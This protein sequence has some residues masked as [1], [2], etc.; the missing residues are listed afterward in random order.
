MSAI[1]NCGVCGI[2]FMDILTKNGVIGLRK[3]SNEDCKNVCCLRCS[4]KCAKQDCQKIQCRKCNTDTEVL[5]CTGCCEHLRSEMEKYKI[6]CPDD[7]KRK[8]VLDNIELAQK[9]QKIEA[10]S[11]RLSQV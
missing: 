10:T 8:I 3:C 9:K 7:H 4:M 6:K 5:V 2:L 11:V 1:D